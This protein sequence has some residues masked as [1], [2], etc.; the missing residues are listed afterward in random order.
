MALQTYF[1]ANLV[2]VNPF[3]RLPLYDDRILQS[4]NNVEN[5]TPHVFAIAENAYRCGCLRLVVDFDSIGRDSAQQ[6]P[7][8]APLELTCCVCRS[9]RDHDLN[10]SMIVRCR[11]IDISLYNLCMI[12][13]GHA[14]GESGA[15][16][17][18]TNKIILQYLAVVSQ[19]KLEEG[20]PS[21]SDWYQ[22]ADGIG[23]TTHSMTL[24]DLAALFLAVAVA[25]AAAAALLGV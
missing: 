16:K 18:E 21:S 19:M 24:P 10:Q 14:S 8:S 6:M 2:A 20:T 4:Y 17:T 12:R 13:F 15:G 1:G 7:S 23:Q 3:R 5:L 22:C 25:A 11:L 9:L